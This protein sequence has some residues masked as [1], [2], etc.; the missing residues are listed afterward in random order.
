MG[1]GDE[2]PGWEPSKVRPQVRTCGSS[3]APALACSMHALL[4]PGQ[5]EGM[6]EPM[7][8]FSPAG[9]SNLLCEFAAGL[10]V[11][12]KISLFQ[13]LSWSGQPEPGFL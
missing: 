2:L 6:A 5:S 8:G 13:V 12:I 3:T 1:H 9:A 10:L 7:S 4:Q 11:A